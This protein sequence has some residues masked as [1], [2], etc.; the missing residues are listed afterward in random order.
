MT[1]IDW[2][3]TVPK[4]FV[5]FVR[6]P[7]LQPS[8]TIVSSVVSAASFDCSQPACFPTAMAFGALSA[9]NANVGHYIYL[10]N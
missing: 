10:I 2:D 1:N 3:R 6:H 4:T 8:T 5:P 9:I 7:K